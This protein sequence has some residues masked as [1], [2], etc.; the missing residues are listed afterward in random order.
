MSDSFNS[1]YL[2]TRESRNKAEMDKL[3]AEADTI[4]QSQQPKAPP[5]APSQPPQ[6]PKKETSP[7][8]FQ[9]TKRATLGGVQDAVYNVSHMADEFSG[10]LN[11]NYLHLRASQPTKFIREGTKEAEKFKQESTLAGN[12]SLKRFDATN[13]TQPETGAGKVARG[14]VS[15]GTTF[16]ATAVATGGLGTVGTGLH[17]ARALAAGLG[18]GAIADFAGQDPTQGNLSN[19]ILEAS[20]GDPAVGKQVFEM[21][22]I[23]PN[24]NA[25]WNRSKNVLEGMGLGIMAEGLVKGVR[26]VAAKMRASGKD[27]AKVVMDELSAPKEDLTGLAVNT[28]KSPDTSL[29]DQIDLLT[30]VS[31]RGPSVFQKKL[32]MKRALEAADAAQAPKGLELEPL[33]KQLDTATAADPMKTAEGIL[34]KSPRE[35]RLEDPNAIPFTRDQPPA[36]PITAGDHLKL[37]EEDLA[38]G[39]AHRAVIDPEDG[40][41]ALTKDAPSPQQLELDIAVPEA[42]NKPA[43]ARTAQEESVLSG[44]KELQEK[45]LEAVSEKAPKAVEKDL[46]TRIAAAEARVAK[47]MDEGADTE[48]AQRVLDSLYKKRDAGL[49]DGASALTKKQADNLATGAAPTVDAIASNNERLLAALGRTQGGMMSPSLL[50]N[51]VAAQAGGVAGYM[52]AEDDASLAERLSLA[53]MGALA[54][55]G[56]KVGLGKKSLKVLS[57]AEKEL[58]DNPHPVVRELSRPEV[59]NIAP[60]SASAKPQPVVRMGGIS[61]IAQAAKEGNLEQVAKE[62]KDDAFNFSRIDTEDDVKELFNAT[63]AAF[64]KEIDAARGGAHVSFDEIKEMAEMTGGGLKSLEELYQG[65]EGLAHRFY[66]HRAMLVASAEK[67]VELARMAKESDSSFNIIAANKQIKLHAMIQAKVNGV[68]TE[69]ARAMAA[70]RLTAG[71]ADFAVN[72]ANSLVEALGGRHAQLK[73]I[74][75]LADIPTPGGLNQAIRMGAMARTRSALTESITMG[76]LWSPVTHVANLTGN[77]LVAIGSIAER[78]GAAAIGSVFRNGDDV[79][80]AGEVKAQFF[81]MLGGLQD[82]L[83]ITKAGRGALGDAAKEAISGNFK[84]AAN[85][86]SANADEFGSAYKAAALGQPTGRSAIH[87]T[88]DTDTRSITAAKLLPMDAPQWARTFVDALGTLGRV[89]GHA[90]AF[91][92]EIFW[93]LNYR[94]ELRAQAYRKAAGEGLQGDELISRVA[95]LLQNPSPDIRGFAIKAAEEGTFTTPMGKF[96]NGFMQTVDA[97]NLGPLPVGRMV[98]PFIKTPYNILR[99]FGERNPLTAGLSAQVREDFIAGGAR[100]DIAIAKMV[101]GSTM[102]MLGTTLAAGLDIGGSHVQIIGGGDM[103]K[104]AEKVGGIQAYSL[105]VGDT[106]YSFN[107]MDPFGMFLGLAADFNDISSHLDESSMGDVVSAAVL[108]MS[109]NLASKSYLSGLSDLMESLTE[110]S[111]GNTVK[112]RKWA[113]N[114]AASAIPFSSAFNTAKKI[115]DPVQREVWDTIDAIKAKLPGFSKDV[116]PVRNVFGEEVTLK[117]GLGP[118]MMS[119]VMTSTESSDPAAKEI[120]RLN[121]D[122]QMPS[123]TLASAPGAP[124]IDLDKWQYDKLSAKAGELFKQRMD[125]LVSNERYQSLPDD[126]S[127][128]LYMEAKEKVIRDQHSLAKREATL[129]LLR[130]DEALQAKWRTHRTN[131][132]GVLHGLIPAPIQ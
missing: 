74:S 68:Q 59:G 17:G 81:G 25:A 2:A 63:E 69:I 78:G 97:A 86:L 22:S 45:A 77:L 121:V 23:D 73:F 60:L 118:D 119:P 90:L 100:R 6:A 123:R 48:T 54:G 99:Y 87:M 51:L 93:S 94:G 65:T 114:Q 125:A 95:S 128:G 40:S 61:R 56:V 39:K 127:G 102:L 29:A 43:A 82:A 4:I 46:A 26:V 70:M 21:L 104:S 76:K 49:H 101:T 38:A 71:S 55:V 34:A 116:P 64:Q 98:V 131:A 35:V 8:F 20:D 44:Y 112:L 5:V 85:V 106:Y 109:R 14:L 108:S 47:L 80:R 53:G 18:R 16:A 103:K 11:E 120:A 31:N 75:D 84:E 9:E 129:W 27:P 50:A 115:D 58:V 32:D 30:G 15:F 96:G 19:L 117:G 42:V 33:G 88:M 132:A 124:S 13:V 113:D 36:A 126:T 122:L 107:R 24:D 1:A 52:S 83:A 110:A 67:V 57:T 130:E 12:L 72:E 62:A 66:A 79:V 37:I 10:W 3:M 89:P 111:K 92:D 105:K 7:G 91:G 41:I 28:A